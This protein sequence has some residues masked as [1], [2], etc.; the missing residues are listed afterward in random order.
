[1]PIFRTAFRATL[2]TELSVDHTRNRNRVS[3]MKAVRIES[4]GNEE[5]MDL[6]ARATEAWSWPST[7]EG[8][9]GGGES[10]GLENPRR[11]R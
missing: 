11:A 1:M 8:E 7:G 4:Y 2:D 9:S 10:S 5:V 6:A 3:V